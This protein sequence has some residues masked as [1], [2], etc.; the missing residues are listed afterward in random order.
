MKL[1]LSLLII[2]MLAATSS[3]AST[4]KVVFSF[5]ERTY[6]DLELYQLPLSPP[7]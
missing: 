3:F 1:R 4:F 7:P 5:D 2:A 6:G